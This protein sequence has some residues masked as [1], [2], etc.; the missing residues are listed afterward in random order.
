MSRFYQSKLRQYSYSLP[1]EFRS[2]LDCRSCWE[3][4]CIRT[5]N[6]VLRTFLFFISLR[7]FWKI[8]FTWN[9]L[10]PTTISRPVPWAIL[11]QGTVWYCL[12][13][14]IYG[15]YFT[16]FTESNYKTFR[17]VLCGFVLVRPEFSKKPVYGDLKPRQCC[18]HQ[19]QVLYLFHEP[20]SFVFANCKTYFL[21]ECLLLPTRFA[22]PKST[23]DIGMCGLR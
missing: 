15:P 6:D 14:Q 1:Q 18:I 3:N 21:T 19:R 2:D 7:K 8:M 11:A 9:V 10:N 16:E 22:L 13:L 4:A 23:T 12:F 17:P 5:E 20:S